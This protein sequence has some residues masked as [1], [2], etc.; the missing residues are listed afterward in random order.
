M[1]AFAA[2]AG[3]AWD[4][5]FRDMAL[6]VSKPSTS[7]VSLRFG[8]SNRFGMISSHSNSAISWWMKRLGIR[9]TPRSS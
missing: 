9:T 8:I 4:S 7:F 1:F 6:A 3:R 5:A 2:P